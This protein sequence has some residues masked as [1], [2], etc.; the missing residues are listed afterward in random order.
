MDTTLLALVILSFLL[1]AFLAPFTTLTLSAIALLAA[2]TTW[3]VWL[4]IHS[5]ESVAEDPVRVP[6]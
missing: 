6:H 4:V 5:F 1:L 3:G 2:V